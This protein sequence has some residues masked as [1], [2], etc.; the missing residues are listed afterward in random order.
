MFYHCKISREESTSLS[1]KN[2]T[3]LRLKNSYFHLILDLSRKMNP[4][5]LVVHPH[6]I[7]CII[8]FVAVVQINRL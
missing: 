7:F 2:N 8:I 1:K 3:A 6:F 5:R 4:L